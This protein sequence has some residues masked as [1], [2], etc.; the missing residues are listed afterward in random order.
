[1]TKE[2]EFHAGKLPGHTHPDE[3]A[4]RKPIN[5]AMLALRYRWWLACGAAIGLAL[6]FGYYL[7]AGPEYDATAQILVSRQHTSPIPAEQRTL[8][9]WGERS[10][11]IAIILSPMIIDRAVETAKLDQL[12]IF[13]AAEDREEVVEDIISGLKVKRTSGQDRSFTNVLTLTYSDKSAHD[14]RAVVQ[15]IVGAYAV[16]LQNTRQEKANE[17]L[18]SVQ[19]AHDDLLSK[20]RQREQEYHE[21]RDSAPFQWKAPL[22]ATAT[23]GNLTTNVHQERII[24]I[25]EQRKLNLL[26]QAELQSR[27]KILAD[28]LK[29]GEPHENLVILVQRFLTQDGTTNIERQRQQDAGIFENRY[30]PMLLEEKKLL[31]DYGTDHPDVQMIQKSLASVREFYRMQGI[32]LPEDLPKSPDGRPQEIPEQDVVASY[33]ESLRLQLSELA[34]RDKELAQVFTD[35][36]ELAKDVAR[37]QAKDQSLNAELTR[38]RDL[39]GQLITQVNQVGIEKDGS[40]YSLK[41]L[42]PV[43]DALS[44]KRILKFVGAGTI[45][46]MGLMAAICILR[47]LSDTRLKTLADVR[48]MI[49][50]P[51]LGS[52]TRFGHQEDRSSPLTAHAHPGMRYLLAPHSLEA[53]NFRSLRAA[54]NIACEDAQAKLLLI[55]S[56]EPSDGKSTTISNLAVAIAQ[57]GKRVLLIDADLRRPTA[58][59]LFRIP[60][61]VGLT[62]VLQG[63]VNWMP[64]V[65]QTLIENLS[66]LPAGPSPENPAELLSSARLSRLLKDARD[67]YDLVLVDAP[68]MLAVSDPCVIARHTER[69]L[70]VVRLGK[71]SMSSMAQARELLKTHG[72]KVLGVVANDLSVNEDTDYVNRGVYYR[73][74]TSEPKEA[75]REP[76]AV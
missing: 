24:A 15:A 42:A 34:L 6:G 7:K 48:T 1:M 33:I 26:R 25:E 62:D 39:W 30:L 17:V 54:V 10:E 68:P 23:D 65:R 16:Y 43:K 51:L 74:Y 18:T 8:S 67:E 2:F 35:E 11:H 32:R 63:E 75:V 29:N 73:E 71:S 57:S 60:A 27:Q 52:I 61:D 59:R 22:G 37:F 49:H 55:T 40:G 14:A 5:F 46:G 4:Y 47:E 36:S 38:L 72:I 50:H 45:A 56:P 28:G 76:V 70:L 3:E 13:R 21:F 19:Q 58:H 44:I 12:S 53:E 41:Q 9:D 69:T 31:R 20:L 66:V 64:L